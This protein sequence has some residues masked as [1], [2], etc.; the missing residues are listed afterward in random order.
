MKVSFEILRN[1]FP[2][3]NEAKIN[4]RSGRWLL[5]NLSSC[6]RHSLHCA[7]RSKVLLLSTVSLSGRLRQQLLLSSQVDQTV[8]LSRKWKSH[9]MGTMMK[10]SF[11]FLLCARLSHRFIPTKW[12][13]PELI[14]ILA[15]N[16][17]VIPKSIYPPFFDLWLIQYDNTEKLFWILN[18]VTF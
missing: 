10:L 1:W 3:Q 8:L 11:C 5:W 16:C 17:V 4:E 18:L 6:L 14:S 9:L 2:Q 7:L 13:C 15:L 12:N